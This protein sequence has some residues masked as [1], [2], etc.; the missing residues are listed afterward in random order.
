MVVRKKKEFV[1]RGCHRV[2]EGEVC[3][4]CNASTSTDWAG[5]LVI[6]D[7]EHSEIAK[8]MNIT[9]SGKYALKVR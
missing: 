2:A 6:I 9:K 8:R 4:I 5:Y 1:C 7:A 3:P